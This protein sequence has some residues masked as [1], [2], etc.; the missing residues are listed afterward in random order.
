MLVRG[1]RYRLDSRRVIIE[2]L[3]R[4]CVRCLP[5]KQ[6]VVVSTRSQ[7]LFIRRPLQS[8][9][10]LLVAKELLLE[11]RGR[12]GVPL[13]NPSVTRPAR[14]RV[15]IPRQRTHSTGVAHHRSD[16]LTPV[17][18]PDLHNAAVGPDGK[19]RAPSDPLDTRNKVGRVRQIAPQVAQLGHLG[20]AC[21]PEVNARAEADAKHIL[22]RPVHQV[23][24]EVVLQVGGIQHFERHLRDL[25]GHLPR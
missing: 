8:A 20:G 10:F 2:P 19:V 5:H 3:H 17:S 16:L 18:V 1:P 22:R 11:Q 21:A 23:E 24:V 7:V 6:L 13:Q 15:A 25:P 9:H 4:L 14:Q 12:P